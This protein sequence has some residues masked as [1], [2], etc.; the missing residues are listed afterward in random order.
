[1][2]CPEPT[3]LSGPGAPARARSAPLHPFSSV[4]PS[5]P[6]LFLLDFFPCSF[7]LC[8]Q[9]PDRGSGTPRKMFPPVGG[10][11][12]QIRTGVGTPRAI[13][14]LCALTGIKQAGPRLATSCQNP[15]CPSI[16]LKNTSPRKPF[17]I[18]PTR[19]ITLPSLPHPCHSIILLVAFSLTFVQLFV[20]PS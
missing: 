11:R 10:G 2:A 12:S 6:T 5:L 8:F 16:Q 14:H 4:L 19:V 20:H 9:L 15:I 3:P 17:R 7:C 13:G 1:M 18:T